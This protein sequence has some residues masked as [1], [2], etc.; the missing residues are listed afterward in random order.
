V[1]D[2]NTGPERNT[3]PSTEPE[4]ESG[5]TPE[6]LTEVPAITYATGPRLRRVRSLPAPPV[7]DE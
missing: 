6:A 3:G 2:Q 4:Q 7:D 1:P 5:D